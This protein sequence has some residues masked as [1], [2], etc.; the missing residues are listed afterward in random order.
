MLKNSSETLTLKLNSHLRILAEASLVFAETGLD[1]ALALDVIPRFLVERL[2]SYCFVHFSSLSGNR[3]PETS[4]FHIDSSKQGT[5]DDVSSQVMT[6]SFYQDIFCIRQPL[7]FLSVGPEMKRIGLEHLLAVPLMQ[8]DKS[9]GVLLLGRGPDASPYSEDEILLIRELAKIIT[10]TLKNAWAFQA[11]KDSLS[12]LN[13]ALDQAPVGFV[14][15]DLD[16]RYIK[17]N[18]AM[19]RPTGRDPSLYVG[20]TVR[21]MVP[22]IADLVDAVVNRVAATGQPVLNYEIRVAQ[23][24]QILNSY[25]VRTSNGNLSG[26][27]S[28]VIDVTEKKE[29]QKDFDLE[30]RRLADFIEKMPGLV[31]EG[32]SCSENGPF[33]ATFMSAF[34]TRV[35]GYAPEELLNDPNNLLKMVHPDDREAFITARGPNAKLTQQNRLEYRCMTKDGRVIHMESNAAPIFDDNGNI[36]G[37]RGVSIDVSDRKINEIEKTRLTNELRRALSLRDEFIAVAAHELKTPL[38]SLR[39]QVE[40]VALI[41]KQG[42]GFE[43]HAEKLQKLVRGLE[44]QVESLTRIVNDMVDVR[45]SAMGELMMQFGQIDLLALA[46]EAVQTLYS[47][48]K[49]VDCRMTFDPDIRYVLH[50]DRVRIG[51]VLLNLLT[52]AAKYGLGRP[53]LLRLS[54][55]SDQIELA[56]SDKGIGIAPEDHAKIF[57]R[58]ISVHNR[59]VSGFGLGLYIVR[60]IV[61]AHGGK[62]QVESQL[63]EG[64]CFRVILP[65]GLA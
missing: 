54:K 56:V 45:R 40:L 37:M 17:V 31:W 62:V 49:S 36:V 7:E 58:Y 33:K 2:G 61:L 47:A 59:S 18:S 57:E 64:A 13:M 34:A 27:C 6:S 23:Y 35:L 55:R 65:I 41:T 43:N 63:G 38:T 32:R 28:F 14:L 5:V 29:L 10:I 22:Q 8:A 50:G 26:V 52:N 12:Q 48:F 11:Q 25:P 4:W 24:Y 60:E 53:I 44:Q 9:A 16:C 19:T 20:K 30:R 1:L 15:V 3:F 21:E 39:L 51:Q 42:G 46:H